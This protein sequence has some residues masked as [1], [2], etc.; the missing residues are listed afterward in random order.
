MSGDC[1][2]DQLGRVQV[3][4]PLPQQRTS[5]L[6]ILSSLTVPESRPRIPDLIWTPD[7]CAHSQV[8]SASGPRSSPEAVRRSNAV[9]STHHLY[10]FTALLRLT[11]SG[12]DRGPEADPT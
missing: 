5:S 11:A 1:T 7:F 8:G 6:P 2:E 12:D 9:K 4:F 3:F 10:P